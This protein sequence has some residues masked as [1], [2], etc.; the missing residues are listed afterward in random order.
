MNELSSIFYW[1]N[2]MQPITLLI[3]LSLLLVIFAVIM[4]ILLE[5]NSITFISK[6]MNDQSSIL[7]SPIEKL[8]LKTS[9]LWILASFC[10]GGFA[11]FFQSNTGTLYW[12]P[13]A[14]IGK[15]ILLLFGW[16]VW[17]II[18]IAELPIAFLQYGNHLDQAI[19][20]SFCTVL[21]ALLSYW[22]VRRTSCNLSLRSSRDIITI[23]LFGITIPALIGTG[24]GSIGLAFI[25]GYLD[26]LRLQDF[27]TRWA[28]NAISTTNLLPAILIC[29]IPKDSTK[30]SKEKSIIIE[31]A[32]VYLLAITLVFFT[33]Q[34]YSPIG[35]ELEHNL[36]YFCFIP[37]IWA[38]TRFN[39]H[40]S[41]ALL[42]FIGIFAIIFT[43][44]F[45]P[46]YF[47]ML[48]TLFFILVISFCGLFLIITYDTERTLR[49][50]IQSMSA[51]INA[52]EERFRRLA[53]NSSDI[54]F[55]SGPNGMEYISPACIPISGFTPEEY[56]ADP[57]LIP[58]NVHPDDL[59]EMVAIDAE[60]SKR[61]V[62]HEL[63]IIH[64]DGHV[65]WTEQNLTPVLDASG[66][67]IGVEGIVRDITK[68]KQA[69]EKLLESE[70]RFQR[71]LTNAP[72]PIM[73]HTEDG[74][75]LF[76]NK[77]WSDLSGYT[78]Q[79][80]PTTAE[81]AEKAYR[82]RQLLNK[83]DHDHLEEL[84][85]PSFE[86][87]CYIKTK[88][89]KRMVWD[90][91][92]ARL[93]EM[94]DGRQVII[95]T[96]RDI[97]ERKHMEE[98]LQESELR[99]R[100]LVE[101]SPYIVHS[102]SNKRGGIYYSAK[103]EEVLG[104]SSEELCANPSLWN[105]LIHPDDHTNTQQTFAAFTDGKSF[106]LEYRIKDKN[107]NIH[108]LRDRSIFRDWKDDEVIIN[109]IA[110]DSTELKNAEAAVAVYLIQMQ[111]L[112]ELTLSINVMDSQSEI[113]KTA[114]IKARKIFGTH[115]AAIVYSENSTDT[116]WVHEVSLSERYSRSTWMLLYQQ[117]N[118]TGIFKNV[119]EKNETI[120]TTRQGSEI[121]SEIFNIISSDQEKISI[122]GWMG[123][124]LI[125]GDGKNMGMFLVCDK[126]EGEFS[127]NDLAALIQLA[128]VISN[129]I[130]RV[131]LMEQV[132][133]A[134][135]RIR[136]L[137]KE[138]ISAQE[139]ERRNLSRDLH[140]D[141]GQSLT[142][143][144][145]S[146][147]LILDDLPKRME[148]IRIRVSETVQIT[149]TMI[150]KIRYLS[151]M[152]RPASLDTIGLNTSLEGMCIDFSKH[153][154]INVQY[155][156]TDVRGLDDAIT[157]SLYRFLQEAL[158]NAAKHGKAK[159]I[160][161]S[162]N[163]DSEQVNLTVKDDG[164]GFIS[165][166]IMEKQSKKGLGLVGTQERLELLKG[167]LIIES[168]EKIGTTLIAQIPLED[169]R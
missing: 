29:L 121:D 90:F 130:E 73:L 65:V 63:R 167:K 71:A 66:N 163:R 150:N 69:E 8:D 40:L 2:S 124:P 35:V 148:A 32:G 109:S 117:F 78:L 46:D 43:S 34:H 53:E 110:S 37:V 82:E 77:A 143:L 137:A 88:D 22:L 27:L 83:M 136:L 157:I 102:F 168:T 49:K 118:S 111:L 146:L 153:T 41:S 169:R 151:H 10:A 54:I 70:E 161:V 125:R 60:L 58:S 101:N 9:I 165:K 129:S 142:A 140:D 162:L 6:K 122:N 97:T 141:A 91:N 87:E 116:Q 134:N 145:I 19:V 120:L 31:I 25:A 36:R 52:R 100:R 138:I 98:M 84:E 72:L 62:R 144:K 112:G 74:E 16:Q 21:E 26:Q 30:N 94:A 17:P 89:G 24:L 103:V 160:W 59:Q 48:E 132:K 159:Y 155:Q 11:I 3:F 44:L 47:S 18:L 96:A 39:R 114:V 68:R 50:S 81:W 12:Y 154:R 152:L 93:G 80:I 5:R 147:Q 164:I 79:D 38:A 123:V 104:Y 126:M 1:L 127:Q 135:E 51:T 92:S 55:R 156:G 4:W 139:S 15:A 64:K 61:K 113:I 57:N 105:N 7:T 75:V 14:A 56:Y 28:G 33:F 108:W 67:R 158:N 107:G 95:I 119:L 115:Q 76:I 20:I 23:L 42:P 13:Q 133:G 166:N 99:Y 128:R 149:D 85:K 45:T 86:G 131:N 106:D